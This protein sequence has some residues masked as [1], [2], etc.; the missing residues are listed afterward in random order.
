M[1]TQACFGAGLSPH[2][3]EPTMAIALLDAGAALIGALGLSYGAPDPPASESDLLAQQLLIALRQPAQRLGMA[4]L[5]AHATMLRDLL[6]HHGS[7][8]ADD[9]KTLLEFV[10]YADPTIPV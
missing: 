6:R 1:I 5:S 9:T 8:D 10:L 3:G 4:F 2:G 7:I